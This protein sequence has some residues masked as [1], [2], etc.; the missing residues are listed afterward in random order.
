MVMSV[1]IFN[2]CVEEPPNSDFSKGLYFQEIQ[3]NISQEE[4]LIQYILDDRS[5]NIKITAI[6]R[7]RIQ[8]L[9]VIV[10][11]NFEKEVLHF[12]NLLQQFSLPQKKKRSAFIK[13]S[14]QFYA[15]LIEPLEE[16]LNRAETLVLIPQGI[17]Q[18]IPFETLVNSS[19]NKAFDQLPFLVKRFNI[20]YQSSI[21]DL[22]Q[23]N[24]NKAQWQ[25]SF[26]GFAPIFNLPDVHISPNESPEIEMRG[27]KINALPFSKEE[28]IS[29]N[30]LIHSSNGLKCKLLLN[31]SANET[32]LKKQLQGK[33][34]YIHIASH[35][36]ANTQQP[37]LSG[38]LCFEESEED[39]I[40]NVEEISKMKIIADL[41]V[42]SSCESGLGKIDGGMLQGI[43]RS[44]I[45]AGVSNVVY[46]LWKVNDK[47]SSKLM[48]DFY[49]AFLKS[50]KSYAEALRMAKLKLIKNPVTASPNIWAPF[51]LGGA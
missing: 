45:D 2:S 49:Y 1:C 15:R 5:D 42:L 43:H 36:F 47:V 41:V 24:E 27:S 39:G 23:T 46:S 20:E 16:I 9:K 37:E 3:Q 51:V 35:S 10:S 21:N 26:V 4:I 14:F 17:L 32:N 48:V 18:L 11:P 13:Q 12:H 19:V 25:D 34:K 30:E 38:I 33:H 44:F 31:A 8:S 40:L 22:L 29:I 7:G 28:V 6:T 50:E